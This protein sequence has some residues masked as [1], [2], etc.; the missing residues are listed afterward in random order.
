MLEVSLLK[1]SFS[2]L[3]LKLP[4]PDA[5]LTVEEVRASIRPGIPIWQPRRLAGR[6]S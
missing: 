6:K 1:R 3:G 2:F 4:D 5:K